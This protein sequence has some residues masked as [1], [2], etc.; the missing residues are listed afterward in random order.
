MP[1][2]FSEEKI[3]KKNKCVKKTY[4]NRFFLH[5]D[6]NFLHKKFVLPGSSVVDYVRSMDLDASQSLANQPET[7]KREIL[8]ILLKTIG[9]FKLYA[10]H[11]L[12]IF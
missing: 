10:E 12:F 4:R 3:C 1:N 7:V 5:T 2:S 9:L 6:F 11:F 8:K